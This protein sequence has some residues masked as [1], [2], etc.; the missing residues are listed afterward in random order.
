MLIPY[1]DL[2]PVVEA[3]SAY[4][5]ISFTSCSIIGGA[6]HC[7]CREEASMPSPEISR[8]SPAQSR[9]LVSCH[10]FGLEISLPSIEPHISAAKSYTS[11]QHRRNLSLSL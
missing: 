11:P 6:T 3:K 5:F 10:Q 9:R 2:L 7:S 4:S 1:S 8:K